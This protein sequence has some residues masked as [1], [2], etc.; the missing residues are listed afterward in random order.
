MMQHSAYPS[1]FGTTVPALTWFEEKGEYQSHKALTDS[2]HP[3][4]LS[5]VARTYGLFQEGETLFLM[6]QHGAHERLNFDLLECRLRE[7]SCPSQ[8]LLSPIPV[9]LSAHQA[10][11]IHRHQVFFHSVGLEVESFGQGTVLLRAVPLGLEK[12][13]S[14]KFFLSFLEKVE[15]LEDSK[16]EKSIRKKIL[17]MIACRASI[18]AGDE[19][20]PQEITSLFERLLKSSNPYFCPHGRPILVKFTL[21]EVHKLFRRK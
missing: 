8:E 1:N 17:M 11:L 12:L 16:D 15:N 4:F 9:Q 5:F 2:F 6:D 13:G 21:D 3:K 19:V 14:K 20:S 18:Q 7:S 10:G